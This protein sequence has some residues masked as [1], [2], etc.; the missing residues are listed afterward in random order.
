MVPLL[1]DPAIQNFDV[2][3]IQEPW[4]NSFVPTSYNPGNS[5]FYLVHQGE[6]NTRVCFYVNK[7]I[8]PETW[9]VEFPSKD[10]CTL[11]IR[12]QMGRSVKTIYIHN[13]YNPSPE[14]LS[15]NEGVS[16]IPALGEALKAH[17]EHLVVGD[18]N[19]HNPYWG[20][21]R[22]RRSHAW[23]RKLIELMERESLD[24]TLPAGTI[25]WERKDQAS[26]IDLTFASEAL[27]EA[28]VRC[29]IMEEIDQSSD[30]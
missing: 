6:E 29:G 11:M 15:T 10:L 19:L 25:T 26:T 27:R 17:G 13:V 4:S 24:L 22:V 28:I 9:K 7:S 21:Q 23:S 5:R 18:F 3:A 20:G 8:D 14:S 16:T 30:H 12:V 2:L 1:A